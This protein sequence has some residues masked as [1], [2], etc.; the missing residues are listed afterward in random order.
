MVQNEIIRTRD[1]IDEGVRNPQRDFWLFVFESDWRTGSF[2]VH[3]KEKEGYKC[4][5]AEIQWI[6]LAI[7]LV[8]IH[9]MI[10]KSIKMHKI[11]DVVRS[12]IAIIEISNKK[13]AY[14][15]W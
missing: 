5:D 1:K 3:D 7:L 13:K 14:R 9:N 11:T 6:L 15:R 10:Q 8:E 12:I 4:R 2:W